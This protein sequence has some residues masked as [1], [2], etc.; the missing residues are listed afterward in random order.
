VLSFHSEHVTNILDKFKNDDIQKAIDRIGL[1]ATPGGGGGVDVSLNGDKII[2]NPNTINFVGDNVT[3]NKRR[4]NIDISIAAGG[5]AGISGPYVASINGITGAVNLKSLAGITSSISGNTYSFG[6]NYLRGGGTFSSVKYPETTDVILLQKPLLSGGSM[7]TTTIKN[8]LYYASGVDTKVSTLNS[9]YIKLFTEVDADT[10]TEKS[11]TFSDFKTLLRG[12]S[13][14]YQLSS[15]AGATQGDRWMSSDT[16]IEYVYVND[17]N[18][19]QWVQ[20]TNTSGGQA[21]SPVYG[22]FYDTTTQGATLGN[23]AYAMRF[24][25][26]DY[27]N[28]VSIVSNSRITL[29]Y[30]GIYNLQFSAQLNK[31]TASKSHVDIWLRK[32]GTNISNT[33]T[34]V[35]LAGSDAKAVAAWNFF[36]GVTAGDYVELMWATDDTN[37]LIL[38]EAANDIH[39]ATPSIILTV[40]KTN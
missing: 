2:R 10:I 19:P 28:G 38:Y 15:P 32:N 39:P 4:K 13:F 27:S 21:Y 11:I 30:T 6:I 8:L 36:V 12:I 34:S 17:G 16:G 37:S 33:N 7:Y 20:P 35:S 25:S 1:L 31:S 29:D 24:N 22:S 26:I 5:G 3:I 18:T 9:E 40:N 14:S 23:S